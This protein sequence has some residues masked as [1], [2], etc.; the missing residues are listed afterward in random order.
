MLK[1][2]VYPE[3]AIHSMITNQ[4]LKALSFKQSLFFALNKIFVVCPLKYFNHP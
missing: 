4:F 2:L 1:V 3:Q